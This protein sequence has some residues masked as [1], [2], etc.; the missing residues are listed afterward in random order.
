MHYLLHIAHPTIF[1][2][3]LVILLIAGWWRFVRYKPITFSYS[4]AAILQHNYYANSGYNKKILFGL[5][6]SLLICLILLTA[7]LQMV[8]VRSHVEVEGIDMMLVLDVSGSMHYADDDSDKR[9]RIE[10]AKQAASS[11]VDQRLHDPIGLVLF[12]KDAVS[13]CP[14]TLDKNVLKSI[15]DDIKLGVINPDGTMLSTALAM[16]V[17]RLKN[18]ISKNKVIILLTDGEPSYGDLDHEAAIALANKFGIKIYTIGIGPDKP[19]LVRV[20]FQIGE[21]PPVNKKLLSYIA[22]KTGGTFFEAK[23]PRELQKIYQAIDQLEKTK[24]ETDIF[25]NYYDIFMPLILVSALLM[26][27]ELFLATFVWFII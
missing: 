6:V 16:A 11:F 4:L 8:D 25:T 5:R 22:Q 27:V 20:G 14:L 12:G 9:T 15:I 18:S 21:I 2:V 7:R 13:R 23:K 1:S 10:A 3:L 19:Q 24:I 26:I 17:N